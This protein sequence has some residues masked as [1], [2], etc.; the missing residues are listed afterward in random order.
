MAD[1]NMPSCMH[2]LG[3]DELVPIYH[4]YTR[5]L[6]MYIETAYP[7][8]FMNPCEITKKIRGKRVLVVDYYFS[9]GKTRKSID[10]FLDPLKS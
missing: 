6:V 1:L 8:F 7:A 9:L 5:R 3:K 2:L 4:T 10:V